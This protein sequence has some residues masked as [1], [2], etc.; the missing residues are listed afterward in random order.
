MDKKRRFE[1]KMLK[2]KKRLTQLGLLSKEGTFNC[3]RTSG[4]P[5]SCY[6]CSPYKFSRK[7]KHKNK[8]E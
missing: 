4:K 1:L 8:D 6:M 5:C 7:T 3:Y 2:F